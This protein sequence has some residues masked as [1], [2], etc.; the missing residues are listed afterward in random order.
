[1]SKQEI[2]EKVIEIVEE[3]M[4][5]ENVAE[6]T[7]MQEDLGI[8]SMNFYELLGRLEDDFHIRMP[9][10]VLAEVDTVQDIAN[11]VERI[12]NR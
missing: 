12:L 2:L 7:H 5:V 11:E 4:E 8:E 1:M 3:I 10:K 9:E 6:N